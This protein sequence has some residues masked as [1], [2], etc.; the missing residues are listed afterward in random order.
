MNGPPLPTS[1]LEAVP[2]LRGA[3]WAALPGLTTG[4]WRATAADGTA[5]VLR[6]TEPQEVAAT[7]YAASMRVGPA[8]RAAVGGWL[9][10]E[11]LSGTHVGVL[12]LSRPPVIEEV[13]ALLYRWHRAPLELQTRPLAEARE[14]YRRQAVHVDAA[15]V[16]TLAPLIADAD[17]REKEL[18]RRPASV[19]TGH[20]DVT[21][22]LL[23]TPQGL[24]LID[25][26]FAAS[27]DPNR[28]LGQLVWEAELSARSANRLV[29][30]Y[31]RPVAAMGSRHRT[32]VAAWT[33]VVGVTWTLWG[34]AQAGLGLWTR[35]SAERLRGHWAAAQPHDT[36]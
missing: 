15:L 33:F 25:F 18:L 5:W 4:A 36:P 6:R 3:T 19:V 10:T 23:R 20:L 29:D 21:A 27:T 24:R 14:M 34:A 2:E 17:R 16:R 35:R 28:E 11:L 30:A 9:V 12:E 13:A 7:E 31:W 22:N 32:D 1:L 26:E 8:V